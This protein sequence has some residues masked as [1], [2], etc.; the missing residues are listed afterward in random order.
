M[1]KLKAVERLASRAATTVPPCTA[2]CPVNTNAREYVLLTG[3]GRFDEAYLAARGPNAFASVCGHACSAPCEDVCTR[4]EFD[5]PVRIRQLKR[6][7]TDR[8]VARDVASQRPQPTGLSVAVVGAGPAGLAAAQ[9]LALLGHRVTV[10][11]AAAEPGGTALLGVPRFRLSKKAIRRDVDA[12]VALGVE[13]RTNTRVGRDVTLE[14]LRDEFDAVLIAAG[15]MRPNDLS[16]P[17]VELDGVVQALDFLEVANLGG[18]PA[19]GDRVAVIGGGYTAMDAARTA[20]RL[21]AS[22]VTVLYRRTR[23]ETEVH[24]E[25]LEETL[26]EG[27]RIQ[28]LVSPLGIVDDGTGHVAAIECIRN[29]LGDPDASGRPRPVPVPGTEFAFPCDMVILA[30]GQW[31]DTQSIDPAFGDALREVD[32][33]TRMT[34][35]PGIFGCGDFITGPTTIIEA[36]AEGRAAAASI[37]RYLHDQFAPGGDWPSAPHDWP[38]IATRLATNGQNGSHAA[39][40]LGIDEP[41]RLPLGLETEVEIGFSER[42]AMAEGLRCLYCGLMP[43]VNLG[44][45]TACHACVVVCPADAIA[46][47]AVDEH[48]N[49]RPLTGERDVLGYVV[50]QDACIRCGRCFGACPTDAIHAIDIPWA[51][52]PG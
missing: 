11:E 8:F 52:R 29:Q 14:A 15:A 42:A 34:R 31:P 26:R 13:I 48:G 37:H 19:C 43:E 44:A 23:R 7:L 4:A 22:Q 41:P 5:R 27:V 17:G 38:F 21:G 2:A 46:R 10:F 25:E 50:D 6:F 9:D 47:V 28:Y 36:V 18:T 16:V 39:S 35:A 1:P 51:S 40:L 24:D 3:E 33:E 45:C 49:P 12:V 32:P 30:L 20:I